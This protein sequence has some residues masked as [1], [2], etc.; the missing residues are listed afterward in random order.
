MS[1]EIVDILE[2]IKVDEQHRR[3]RGSG[4]GA[5]QGILDLSEEGDLEAGAGTAGEVATR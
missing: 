2:P 5:L 1:E 3:V 4:G